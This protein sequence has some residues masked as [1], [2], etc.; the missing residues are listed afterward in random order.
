MYVVVAVLFSDGDQIPDIPLFEIVGRGV[1]ASPLQIGAT[2]VKVG[3]IFGFTVIVNVV[4]DAHCPEVGVNVYVV[5]NELFNAGNH[6]PVIPLFEV[7]GKAL[8]FCPMHIG[9][10]AV[11][12]GVII[13]FT[14]I[15]RVAIVAHCSS[16]GVKV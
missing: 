7:V 3:T 2:A 8:R 13:G 10:T 5:V 12:V 6:V 4:V 14:K 11:K 1:N 9:A 15:E 16:F